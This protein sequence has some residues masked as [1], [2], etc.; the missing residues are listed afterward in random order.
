MIP[1]L[2]WIK[3]GALLLAVGAFAWLVDDY[4]YQRRVAG[5][6][7][8]V[9]EQMEALDAEKDAAHALEIAQE[10]ARALYAQAAA[11][12]RMEAATTLAADLAALREIPDDPSCPLPAPIGRALDLLRE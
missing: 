3:V 7:A 2:F 6:R 1:S 4:A 8:A 11:D 9:I 10:R 12:R 5:E